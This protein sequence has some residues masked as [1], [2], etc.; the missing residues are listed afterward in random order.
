[1]E[2]EPMLSRHEYKPRYA[3]KAD[4]S[5]S[6]VALAMKQ[7]AMAGSGA[8]EQEEKQARKF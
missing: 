3:P 1:M 6:S 2:P 8:N 4:P 5:V 7:N